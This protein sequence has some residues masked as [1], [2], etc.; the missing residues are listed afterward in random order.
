MFVSTQHVGFGAGG[1][2]TSCRY[3]RLT[4]ASTAGATSIAILWEVDWSND[5]GSTLYPSSNMTTNSA[6]SP[7][8]ALADSEFDSSFR[9]FQAFD[10]NNATRW[11]SANSAMPH[12]IQ[13]DLGAGNAIAPNWIRWRV[14]ND[15]TDYSPASGSVKGSNTGSFSGEE[16]TFHTFSGLSGNA[17][18][19]N[20]IRTW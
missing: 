2:S 7:L 16:T 18:G 8:V 17:D 6:P 3:L 10:G 13:V 15:G 4:I 14:Y 12:W 9:A 1:N 20:V 5:G 19:T 11:T